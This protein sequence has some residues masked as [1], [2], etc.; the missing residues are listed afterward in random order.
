MRERP[1]SKA[2][3]I[4]EAQAVRARHFWTSVAYEVYWQCEPEAAKAAYQVYLNESVQER[5]R[6]SRLLQK[7]G[8]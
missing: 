3:R 2:G 1:D 8:R 7:I 6:A 5:I 4:R